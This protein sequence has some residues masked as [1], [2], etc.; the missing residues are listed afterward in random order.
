MGS[1]P[2]E[3]LRTLEDFWVF[4]APVRHYHDLTTTRPVRRCRTG[5]E[6]PELNRPACISAV[7]MHLVTYTAAA[8]GPR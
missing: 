5:V 2:E 1:F 6:K 8:R 3:E 7:V 4:C